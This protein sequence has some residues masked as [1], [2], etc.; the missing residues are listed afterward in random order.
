LLLIAPAAYS[1]TTWRAPVEGTFPAA[2]PHKA[3]G[4]GGIGLPRRDYPRERLLASYALA[5][6][7]GTRWALLFDASNTA[8]P[9]I[10]SGVNAGALAGYSGTDPVLDGRALARLVARREARYVV[11]GGEF[12]TRGGNRATAATIKACRELPA[13]EWQGA[14]IFLHSL[15]LFD[16]AGRERQ[17]AAG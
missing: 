15:V 11:L 13:A 1:T 17:L 12:S 2:G 14:P 5:H 6:G 9:Q 3:T 10:L 4:R 7:A 8:A 16:C